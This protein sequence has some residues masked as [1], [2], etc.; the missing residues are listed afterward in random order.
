MIKPKNC[1]YPGLDVCSRCP[2]YI[3]DTDSCGGMVTASSAINDAESFSAVSALSASSSASSY[4]D[5]L[6]RYEEERNRLLQLSKEDLVDL[7][8]HRPQYY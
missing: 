7:I 2:Y 8:I 1:K 5:R 3:P 4:E 6:K